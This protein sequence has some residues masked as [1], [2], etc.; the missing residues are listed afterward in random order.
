MLLELGTGW[1]WA[2]RAPPFL[3]LLEEML[4]QPWKSCLQS[5]SAQT[6]RMGTG[7]GGCDSTHRS[8]ALQ[9]PP[10]SRLALGG[11]EPCGRESCKFSCLCP[12]MG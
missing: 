5:S 12:T 3:A 9:E 8:P 6:A 11:N 10:R 1:Q 4:R 2:V 7:G